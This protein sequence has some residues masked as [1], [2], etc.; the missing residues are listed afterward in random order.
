MARRIEDEQLLKKLTKIAKE[1]ASKIN[2]KFGSV[3]IIETTDNKLLALEVNSGVM[4]DNY[5]RLNPI[6]Y[7]IVKEIYTEAI[8]TLFIE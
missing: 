8:E 5:I 7:N 4:L 2:L 6:D 1:I 3:D